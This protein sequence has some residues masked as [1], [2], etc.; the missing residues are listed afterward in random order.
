MPYRL[1]ISRR[2][3]REIRKLP[4][5]A[6]SRVEAAIEGLAEDPRPPG[7]KRLRG[8]AGYR[9]RTGDYRVLYEVDDE[10]STV[11]VYKAGHRRD[12]YR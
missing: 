10:E 3:A 9:V 8:G 2:A 6:R 7:C 5:E 12:V 4:Q 1:L 11:T